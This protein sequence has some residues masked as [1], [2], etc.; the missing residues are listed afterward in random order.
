MGWCVTASPQPLQQVQPRVTPSLLQVSPCPDSAEGCFLL[1][2]QTLIRFQG[3]LLKLGP[4]LSSP[5]W[6]GHGGRICQQTLGPKVIAWL[7]TVGSIVCVAG[8][9]GQGAALV[10]RLAGALK[11]EHAGSRVAAPLVPGRHRALPRDLA[12]AA[13]K[14]LM[15][16]GRV[17]ADPSH[18]TSTPAAARRLGFC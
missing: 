14:A 6:P 17:P 1:C 12:Q 10:P 18:A 7:F 11:F 8:A 9:R 16:G 5:L 15:A 13:Q 3:S 2:S 4:H